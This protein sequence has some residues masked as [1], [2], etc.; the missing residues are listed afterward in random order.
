[1]NSHIAHLSQW[2]AVGRKIILSAA[3]LSLPICAAWS[4]TTATVTVNASSVSATVPPEGYGLNT[5]VYDSY[6]VSS[7][8][9]AQ[10]KASGIN[11]LRY[12]GGS[13]SDAFNFIGCTDQSMNFSLG[14]DTSDNFLNF[15]NDLAIPTGAKPVITLN[16]GSNIGGTGGGQPSEAATWVQCANV[17]NNYGIVYWEIGNEVYGNGYYNGWNW[18]TD[19]HDTDTNA[20]ARVGNSALSPTAYGT[21]A[22]AFVKAI[23]AVDP[24]IKACLSI[25][26]DASG[27]DQS[28]FQAISSALSGSGYSPDCVID[29]WYPSLPDSQVLAAQA[30]I[31]SLVGTIRSEL[32]SYYTLGNKDEI[33]ILVTETGPV[34]EGGDYEFLFT[35]DD[36]LTWFENGAYNVDFEDLHQGYLA[37]PGDAGDPSGSYL[38][39]YGPWYGVSL[40]SLAARPGDKMVAATSSNSLLRAHAVN[41]TDGKVGVVLIND[42]P[43]NSTSVSVSVSGATLSNSGTQYSFG[44]ANY[45]SG[46]WIANSGIG[47]S[48]IGGVGDNFTVTVPAYSATAVLIP[49]GGGGTCTATAIVPYISV[50]GVWSATAESS[51]TVASGTVV[52]LGP[53]PVGGTWSWTGPNGFTSAAREI[54]KIALSSGVNTY[55]ATYT[56]S[57]GAKSTQVFT[58]TVSGGGG[59]GTLI[60]NGTYIVTA[61]NSGLAIDDPDFSTKEGE[62]VDIYTVNDGANQQWKVANLGSNVITLTNVSSGQALDVVGASKASGALVDQWPANGQTNQQW[63][64]ISVAGGAFELTSVNSGLALSVVG[65]GTGKETEIDQLAYSGSASQQWKFTSY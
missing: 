1:M 24:N 27:W 52:D 15:M 37:S 50:A 8:V 17:T 21:N 16:Y 63:K 48:S 7:G 19:L 31:P 11:S 34:S 6:M 64:V 43:N 5:D 41:R 65:G 38:D 36:Y 10:L 40:S 29:H 14:W 58:V 42:D 9:A 32:N 59:T 44:N 61:V 35:V 60:A 54:D 13:Y 62:D 22:A 18:E 28:V 2:T 33:E 26:T 47:E 23:K 57:C 55:T 3:V 49:S 53:Q 25:R 30:G 12:P 56:N 51:V 4:E 45:S 46:S 20:A 39:P